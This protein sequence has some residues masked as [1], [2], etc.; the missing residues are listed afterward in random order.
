MTT[1]F[2]ASGNNG[3]RGGQFRDFRTDTKKYDLWGHI[4]YINLI[5][6]KYGTNREIEM[7]IGSLVE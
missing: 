4:N 6:K 5:M 1:S 7:T 2:D 3:L